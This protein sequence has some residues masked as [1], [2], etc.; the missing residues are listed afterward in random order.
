MPGVGVYA[1]IS[2]DRAGS[3]LGV[4]RQQ[5][6]CEALA[7]ARGW[8]VVETYVDNDISAYRGKA[9]PG[10]GR[11][12]TDLS[13]GR[14]GGV[15][16]WHPD[17]LH[18]SP[19]ELEAFIDAVEATGAVVATVQAGDVDLSTPSGRM[20]ARIVGAVAR[21]ESEHKAE[22]QKR[23]HLELAQAGKPAGGG[24]RPFGFE[25]DR[26]TVRDDEAEI[27]R[28]MATRV[29]AGESLRGVV[30]ELNA[31]GITTPTGKAW[32]QYSARRMLLSPRI[33]GMREHR[34][35]PVA[36]A[37]WPAI[38]D[39]GTWEA[40]RRVLL[41]PARVTNRTARSY[42]L[43]G[44]AR[45]GLCDARLVA[46]PRSD[47]ARCYVC[48]TGPGFKGCGKIRV[49][50]EPLEDLAVDMVLAAIDGPGLARARE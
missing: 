11:L 10:Y 48:S 1:R 32:R 28:D 4:A 27:V 25:A 29:A 17:R 23:K 45:C 30:V 42:L 5:G 40:C 36:E 2:D 22:R 47:K 37:S 26:V 3:G 18:R 13:T 39:R 46:R 41:D 20:V 43:K 34:G 15:V 12:L 33:A 14:I 7:K 8:D 44:I 21:H 24:H 50:A 16:A 38:V 49:L 9:R 6:D 35:Q 31:R 19:I